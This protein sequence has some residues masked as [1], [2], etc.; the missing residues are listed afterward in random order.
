MTPQPGSPVNKASI[1][2]ERAAKRAKK[3]E[4]YHR[5]QKRGKRNRLIGIIGGAV[6]V[7]AIVALVVAAFVLAPKAANYA[8]G[9]AGDASKIDG[10]ETFT[11]TTGHVETAVTYE[12]TPPAGGEHNP[13]WLNCGVYDQAVP[14]ENAV[15]SLEHGA[16]W[17]TY[18]PS[19]SDAQL[20]TLKAKLP[21]T[22]VIL[23]PF[24]GIPAPIVLSG[25][26]SQ[27]KVNSADDPRITEFFT[28]FWKSTNVPE[29]NS[30]CSG[31][32]DAPGKVS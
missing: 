3:L 10:V 11:N 23:S 19:I 15:H 8:G 18:D 13:A 30:P 32:L 21:S 1:K 28:E 25:W 6:A 24:E 29:N 9:G 12:Q 7:V 17:V 31:A 26:N 20:K 22:Y 27:L 4:E 16:I 5:Q 14:N 2:D